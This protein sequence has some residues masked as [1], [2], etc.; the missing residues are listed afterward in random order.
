MDLDPY[1]PYLDLEQHSGS[2]STASL[3][4]EKDLRKTSEAL[5]HKLLSLTSPRMDKKI[6]DVLLLNGRCGHASKQ[7]NSC[8]LTYLV[9]GIMQIFMSHISRLDDKAAPAKPLEKCS[10]KE[11]LEHARHQRDVDDMEAI[12]RSYHA[13]Q[14]IE[15]LN[16]KHKK[17]IH[18]RFSEIGTVQSDVSL[19]YHPTPN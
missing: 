4:N 1:P 6:I 12:K 9:L 15:S 14:R 17:V 10:L 3:P 19:R 13:M 18:E 2:E 5:V 16:P 11:Q 8:I 7:A